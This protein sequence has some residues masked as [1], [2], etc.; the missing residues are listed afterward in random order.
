MINE[1]CIISVDDTR[2]ENKEYIRT[3]MGANEASI[4]YVDGRI[5]SEL[6]KAFIKWNSIETPGPYK[7]GEFGIFYSVLN[8]LE[9]GANNNGIVYFEDD[10]VPVPNIHSRLNDILNYLPSNTDMFAL[11][12]PKNQ[13]HDYKNVCGYNNDG[14]PQYGTGRGNSIFDIGHS[15]I[16][17]L[18][19]GYGNVAMAF[20]RRGSERMLDYI[21][22]RG[23]FSPIDCLICIAVHSG[24]LKGYSLMPKAAPLV[25][26]DWNRPTTIHTSKWGYIAELMEDK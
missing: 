24:Y 14:E 12:S 7:A 18:W 21:E 19:Q 15:E 11:W 5:P 6:S 23:F 4:Q 1:Y 8:C 26:Y 16:C 22:K 3:C 25:N 17:Y 20:T 9:Y 10:A 2:H 13:Q